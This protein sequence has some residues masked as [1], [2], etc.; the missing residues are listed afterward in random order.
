MKYL[1]SPYTHDNSNVR[2]LRYDWAC[3]AASHFM[4]QGTHILSPIAFSHPVAKYGLPTDWA[5]W[6][7]YDA[8]CL[9]VCDELWILMLVGWETSVGVTAEIKIAKKLGMPIRYIHVIGDIDN[10]IFRISDAGCVL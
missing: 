10:P 7:E 1:A 5:Y 8:W 3:K 2:S 6:A 4:L 9:E